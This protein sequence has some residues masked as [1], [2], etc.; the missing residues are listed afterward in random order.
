[1][2][3]LM[4]RYAIM[5]DDKVQVTLYWTTVHGTCHL[6]SVPE[7]AVDVQV[8]VDRDYPDYGLFSLV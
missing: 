5:L 7:A 3:S 8:W 2:C 1:M 4:Q 6:G